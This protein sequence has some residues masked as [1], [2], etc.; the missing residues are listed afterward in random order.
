MLSTGCEKARLDA[1]LLSG[2]LPALRGAGDR[3]T[4]DGPSATPSTRTTLITR[5]LAP[6]LARALTPA[7]S[8]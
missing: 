8:S 1:R 3:V 6:P 4:P 7:L 5:T 2:P